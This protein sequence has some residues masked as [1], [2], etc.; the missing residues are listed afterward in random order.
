MHMVPLLLPLLQGTAAAKAPAFAA[1]WAANIWALPNGVLPA[2][3]VI[4]SGDF[5]MT[6]QTNNDTGCVE[7]WL[8]LNSMWGMPPRAE[9]PANNTKGS[10]NTFVQTAPYQMQE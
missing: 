1:T 8:G 3:P 2:G 9:N 6:L 7:L 4:G 10:G 5:G